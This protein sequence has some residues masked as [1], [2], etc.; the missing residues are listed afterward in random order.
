MDALSTPVLSAWLHGE[1]QRLVIGTWRGLSGIQ[2]WGNRW[3]VSEFRLS[4]RCGHRSVMWPPGDFQSRF[5]VDHRVL[6]AGFYSM[7]SNDRVIRRLDPKGVL[8]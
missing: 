3:N 4:E 1:R 2:D 5:D 8:R 7:N 6:R